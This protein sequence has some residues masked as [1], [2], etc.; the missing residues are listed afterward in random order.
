MISPTTTAIEI[1][2]IAKHDIPDE[3]KLKLIAMI[4]QDYGEDKLNDNVIY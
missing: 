4:V 2:E 1:L 3:E